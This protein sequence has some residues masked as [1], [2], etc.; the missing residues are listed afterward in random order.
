MIV[1][2]NKIKI[3]KKVTILGNFDLF[4]QKFKSLKKAKK[5]LRH[6]FKNIFCD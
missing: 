2:I 6:F 1:K 3:V 4:Y 5:D